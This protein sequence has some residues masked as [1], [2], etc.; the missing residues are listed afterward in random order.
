MNSDGWHVLQSLFIILSIR[1]SPNKFHCR[2]IHSV[3]VY[4]RRGRSLLQLSP[5]SIR[6]RYVFTAFLA[7]CIV[8]SL[9]DLSLLLYF[10]L[11]YGLYGSTFWLLVWLWL[12]EKQEVLQEYNWLIGCAKLYYI[13]LHYYRC[14][15]NEQKL[16]YF[17]SIKKSQDKGRYVNT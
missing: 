16:T 1:Y 9:M 4:R 2:K 12:W 13:I 3:N 17:A 8:Y 6:P 15:I 11:L 14:P 5:L 7:T 10:M